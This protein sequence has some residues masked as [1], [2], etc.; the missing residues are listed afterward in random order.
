MIINEYDEVLL[1]DG[2]TGTVMSV[3]APREEY[4]IDIGRTSETWDNIFIKH[5]DIVEVIKRAE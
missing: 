4:N 3:C 5:E 2:R 1:K